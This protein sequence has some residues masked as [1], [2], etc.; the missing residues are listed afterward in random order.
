[1]RLEILSYKLKFDL[2][3]ETW[4]VRDEH[5]NATI[6]KVRR[7]FSN[8]ACSNKT[9][10]SGHVMGLLELI[11][12]TKETEKGNDYFCFILNFNVTVLDNHLIL[13]ILWLGIYLYE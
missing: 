7:I 5:Q 10:L 9:Y 4:L 1:M 3:L 6:R 8:G 11:D 2:I 12:R 13:R